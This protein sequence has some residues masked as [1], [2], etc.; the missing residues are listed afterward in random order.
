M[1]KIL[2]FALFFALVFCNLNLTAQTNHDTSTPDVRIARNENYTLVKILNS[3]HWPYDISSNKKHIAIQGLGV[4]DS[5]Y[6]SEETGAKRIK[7]YAYAVSDEGK[8]AG[9]YTNDLGMNVAGLWSPK[10]N[11][12]EFLGMNPYFPE[13]STVEG[14]TEYNGA[15]SMT[16]DGHALGIMQI[17]PDWTTTS[18]LWTRQDG[19]VQLPN[20]DSP[21]TRP[22][23]ISDDGKTI[24]GHAVHKDKGEWVPCYWRNGKIYGFQHIFGEALNVSHNGNYICGYLGDNHGFIYDIYED[25]LI[26]VKNTLEPD[27]GL[28]FVCI[29]NNGIAYG[30]SDGGSPS[31][32]KAVIYI[33]GEL[34]F[35]T[36]YL[37][38]NGVEEA[39]NW[40]I[41]S[42]NDV[43]EDGKTFIGAGTIDGAECT[44]VMTLEG[45]SCEAPKNL[46][47]TIEET[48]NIVLDWEAPENAEN[49]TY[50][51]LINYTGAAFAEGLTE[52]TF[53]FDN[54]EAG[55]YQYSIRAKTN[56]GECISKVSNTVYPT[57]LP[58]P[59]HNK[60]ELIIVATDYFGDGWDF[61]YISI[62]GSMSDLTYDVKLTD[63]GDTLKPDTL[64][65][66]LCPDTYQFTWVPGNW[67]EENGFIIYFQGEELY[68]VNIGD[69][70]ENF[71]TKPMFFEYE[72][73][74]DPRP[75][76]PTPTN[77][78]ATAE[79]T[80]EISLSWN[81]VENATSYNVYMYN[82]LIASVTETSYKA[83]NLDCYSE[84]LFNVTAISDD[85][86]SEKTKN[87]RARTL[88]L[89]TAVPT[90]LTAEAISNTKINLSWDASENALNYNIYI[91]DSLVANDVADTT[92]IVEKLT[93]N[94]EY[95]FTVTA[96]RRDFE[97]EKSEA[98]CETTLN[99]D[100]EEPEPTA[101]AAPVINVYAESEYYIIIEWNAVENATLYSIYYENEYLGDTEDTIVRIEVDVPGAEYCFTVT[102][103][104]EI[105]ESEPSEEGCATTPTNVM[106][107]NES[108]VNIYPNPVDDILFITTD[109]SVKEI[110]ICTI[111]GVTVYSLQATDNR[112]LSIDVTD[113]NSGIY[114]VKL[115]TD[116][117][118]TVRRIL[119]F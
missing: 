104:N 54:M 18:Y 99:N 39:A 96:L 31:D 9:S 25:E 84:Y 3:Y 66:M 14:D 115:K 107:Q 69:I 118:E 73:D 61:G 51:I 92:C 59:E 47:Y 114:F 7:G 42:I 89:T 56:N 16:N 72:L 79:S 75:F 34:M 98:V 110:N 103:S 85:G 90:N 27:F 82:E 113:L 109:E 44:F 112:Q 60:G 70:N 21:G 33:A 63:G 45:T 108:S 35:F 50:D 29:A 23:A 19:Y 1:K 78:T 97:S 100:E 5:Y 87:V 67:N 57:V 46:T 62:K 12:W 38:M 80:S 111:T 77:L 88:D 28:S 40:S 86:E 76:T 95:C 68:R 65:V 2:H 55:E 53:T 119:K 20:G 105:G 116:N 37:K 11:D 74:C 48:N 24:A 64:S 102:A 81:T 58:C 101:P 93:K 6:W 15:W 32:R 117:G 106:T 17:N 8:V 52:T 91:N 41:Y 26:K 36:E 13:F 10:T 94:T 22:N 83:D 43:T 49:V 71:L 30:Y 4:S